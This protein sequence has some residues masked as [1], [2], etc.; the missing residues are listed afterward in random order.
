MMTWKLLDLL[1]VAFHSALILFNLF[2]WLFRRTRRLN[3]L[4]LVLTG[5]SWTV[6]GIFYGFGYC[7]F[8]DWHWQVLEELGR[9]ARQ[10]SYVQYLLERVAGVEVTAGTA[11]TLTLVVFG[12]SLAASLYMNFIFDRRKRD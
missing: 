8:T 2:G 6:L 9:P 3:L 5:L 10:T 11:D 12:A 7:P 4:T 1:F